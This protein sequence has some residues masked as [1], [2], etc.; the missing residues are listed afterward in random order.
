MRL[1]IAVRT[2][3]VVVLVAAGFVAL[4]PAPAGAAAL[5]ATLV[6]QH[7]TSSWGRPSPDPSG[8]TYLPA[9]NQLLIADGEVDEMPLY[10]GTNLFVSSLTGV[11]QSSF[12]GGTS[13]PWSDE[14]TGIGYRPSNGYVYVSDDDADR[15]FQVVAGA[16]G[17][18]GTPDDTV[19]SFSTRPQ[20]GDAED[21][22]IDMDVTNNGH[23][24]VIDG[25][26]KDVLDY[27]PG[28]NGRFDGIPPAGDDTVV[29]MDVGQ[30]GAGDPEGIEYYPGR[31][32][33]LV[34]DDTSGRIYELTRQGALL[35]TIS[36]A[37]A[38]PRKAA[39]MTLAP[40]SNGS[41]AQNLYIVDRGTDNDSNPNE[42]DGR[43]YEMAVTL[44]PVPTGSNQAPT[45]NAGPDQTVTLPS[46]ATL[47]GSITDDGLPNP[48]GTTTAT[49]SKVSGPGTV[50][51]GNANAPSTTASFSAGGSY[52]L[53]L[54][55]NDGQLQ[56]SDDVSV[57]VGTGDPGGGGSNVLDVP[58]RTGADD[59]E[60]RNSTRAVSL[61]STDLDLV[62][63]GTA[64]QTVGLRFTEVTV[65]RGATIT[66]AYV[67]FQVDEA[68][69]AA[70]NL[71]IAGQAAD[72]P[73]AFT[74][75][76]GDV[77]GRPRT[78]AS[79]GWTP[80]SWPT[81]GARGQDQQ[82]A[83]LTPVVQEI[84][85]RSGWASGNALVLVLTGSGTRLAE[86]ANGAPGGAP[87]LHIEYGGTGP[88]NTQPSVNAGADQTVTLPAAATLDGTV[89]D[90]G[91]PTGT[92]TTTW[93]KVTG[94]GTVTFASAS[95]VDTTATFS[96]A[97]SY[98]L[99]LTANDGQLQAND[100]VA[101]TVLDGGT[102]PTNTAPQVNAGAD[103]AVTMPAA[104]TLDGTVTDDGLPS[105]PAVT[106]VT[107]SQVSGPGTVS[108]ADSHAVDTTATF[109]AG[110]RYVLRLTAEDGSPQQGSDD[111]TVTVTDPAA[112][113]PTALEVPVRASADDAEERVST[114]AVSLTSGDLNLGQDGTANQVSALRFTGV[115]IPAGATITAAWVQFQVDEV[116]TAACTVTV[117]GEAAVNAAAFT[118]T[119]RS[120]SSRAGTAAA[121]TWTPAS[122]PTAGARGGDQRTPDLAA[123]VQEIVGQGGWASGNALVLTV[124]GTGTRVAES[125]DGGAAR[126][127][128]LHVEYTA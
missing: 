27:G 87:V 57:V 119:A 95:S 75:T 34:L 86:S 84:V 96:A 92:L 52:V 12:P 105:P 66:R 65:P 80:P 115:S 54:T 7:S 97:G 36:I 112:P 102:T 47:T 82:T 39:G 14:P 104:A 122:W 90:D 99:R 121:V 37:A 9:T 98:V 19:T 60:E 126:A 127:P 26:N 18:Y 74:T 2:V 42:N 38:S 116:S 30:Y 83:N 58:V 69:T 45:V 106:T 59:A 6:A 1:P 29:V 8:I 40:A 100:D 22:T 5:T 72:N 111:V 88:A 101:V 113:A 109:S 16:D 21:V 41:G 61:T 15:I 4:A 107:W 55:A 50:T 23:L 89:T 124:T 48:P 76:A 117:R 24:L 3:P 64:P 94:P 73:P 53:R 10:A 123:V 70:A 114:G 32:T 68:T 46:A 20:S 67:Q 81:V 91:R 44:P 35:N 108:F 120:I 28:T 110:G 31:N 85:S 93:T 78:T 56:T 103:Q 79:V 77:S 43:F 13:L 33:I 63:D 62:T 125:Y 128:V 49:W 71:T 17:R 118:T 25:V 11:Q 51:F